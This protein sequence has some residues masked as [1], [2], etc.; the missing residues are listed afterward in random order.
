MDSSESYNERRSISLANLSRKSA[1]TDDDEPATAARSKRVSEL[2]ENN[3]N[4]RD[5]L[6][7]SLALNST[8]PGLLIVE[9]ETMFDHQNK[10]NNNNS[11]LGL[12]SHASLRTK[13]AKNSGQKSKKEKH[14]PSPQ[15]TSRPHSQEMNALG[16]PNRL[17]SAERL[18]NHHHAHKSSSPSRF[19]QRAVDVN[20]YLASN[21]ENDY[22]ADDHNRDNFTSP[23]SREI[24]IKTSGDGSNRAGKQSSSSPGDR[25]HEQQIT[26]DK[27]YSKSN[28]V[29]RTWSSA[30]DRNF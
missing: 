14:S 29:S 10:N 16:R 17:A 6:V 4:T 19:N 27:F 1:H 21:N 22:D 2:F 3:K 13:M 28:I 26:C 9:K 23:I 18:K 24:P 15:A 5:S 12:A 20:V 7:C 30:S 25:F 8:N 11:V